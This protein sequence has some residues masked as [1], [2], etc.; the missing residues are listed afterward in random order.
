VQNRET[1]YSPRAILLFK[2]VRYGV[3]CFQ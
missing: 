1:A 3:W 2:Q